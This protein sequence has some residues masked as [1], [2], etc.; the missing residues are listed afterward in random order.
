[1]T[2]SY[3]TLIETEQW[4]TRLKGL[5]GALVEALREFGAPEH[6]NG[7]LFYDHLQP[8]FAQAELLS[9]C[10]KKRRRLFE[11]AKGASHLFE[12]GVNGGHSMFL[13]LSAN[14]NLKCDGVDICQQVQPKWGRVDI[15]VP[16]AI[17]WL[18]LEFETEINLHIG[19]SSLVVP[20]FAYENGDAEIDLLHLDGDK[21]SY[22]RD[23]INIE[24]RLQ[25]GATIIIDDTNMGGC[26]RV[27]EKICLLGLGK[28]HPD[29][30]DFD[31]EKYQNIVLVYTGK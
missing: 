29:F 6:L 30:P 31:D 1:M 18:Q 28:P 2:T 10:N 21:R 4:Q 7:N 19:R 25:A 14:P 24:P 9:D 27:A 13:A 26:R 17:K 11:L 22:L 16:A 15:Y 8:N 12:V 23:F 5:N 3:E 20:K